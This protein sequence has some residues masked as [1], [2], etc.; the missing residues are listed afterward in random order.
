MGEIATYSKSRIP[1]IRL[2]DDSYVGVDNLLPEMQGKAS[3]VHT[4]STGTSIAYEVG[5]LLIG[6]IRPYLK[7]I[8]LANSS[9]GCNQDVLVVRIRE[10][11]R[12]N[13]S[14][15]FL[16]YTLASD[17]FF[18]YDMQHAKGAKMPRGD[19]AA[20]MKY[21]ISVPPLQDQARIVA[22][23]D[24]LDVLVNNLSSG[25]SAEISARRQQFEHYRDRLLTFKEAA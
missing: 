19:K 21:P 17:D 20:I 22:V 14:P 3:S 11:E 5:D 16:Y 23:L 7:K 12:I 15:L 2:N 13:I 9:G 8:W 6:N 24:K 4:P 25:L 18:A 1:S 10:E